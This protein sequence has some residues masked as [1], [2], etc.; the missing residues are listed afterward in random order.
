MSAL[1]QVKDLKK[2]F[3]IRSGVLRNVS[4]HVKAVDGVSFEI[5]AGET[6]GLVGES[7]SGKSTVARLMLRLISATQGQVL[8]EGQDVTAA[9]RREMKELRRKM[10]IV[11]QDPAASMNPRATI[12]WSLRRPLITNGVEPGQIDGL[13]RNILRKVN[14]GPEMLERY[15]H[16]LSGGQQ[17]RISVAR[18]LLLRPRLLVLDEPTSALDISVQAQVLNLLLDLQE[19]FQLAYLF[20]TH[21]LNVVRYI[22]DR[23]AIMYLGKL[24]EIGPV[25]V[26]LSNPLHPYTRGLASSSPPLSPHERGR[27]RLLLHESPPSLIDL[28]SGCRLHPRCPYKEERCE[29]QTPELRELQKGHWSACL[30]A[31][32]LNELYKDA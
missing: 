25:R 31:E 7:G 4:S 11:F 27:N 2:H 29:T 20:I 14:L 5:A 15:P 1:A 30:R 21:D 8:L 32:E 12:K 28:P 10:G 24:M 19:E 6:L 18:S 3:E 22:S 13:I 26:V 9:G 17:Q 16:Q 23:V